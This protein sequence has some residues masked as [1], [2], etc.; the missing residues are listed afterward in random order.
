MRYGRNGKANPG[1]N[2]D[3]EFSGSF[4]RSCALDAMVCTAAER[5]PGSIRPLGKVG[6]HIQ[7]DPSFRQTP[8]CGNWTPSTGA[9]GRVFLQRPWHNS[10]AAY[11]LNVTEKAGAGS[12]ALREDED[13]EKKRKKIAVHHPRREG[14]LM[15]FDLLMRQPHGNAVVLFATG[16]GFL[17]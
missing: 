17:G 12:M 13:E 15:A 4:F 16:G 5:W 9:G 6:S 14:Q 10:V 11:Q 2:L 3:A 1:D 8:D 7:L